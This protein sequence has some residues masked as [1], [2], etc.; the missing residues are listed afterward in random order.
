MGDTFEKV[1]E[2]V[3]DYTPV[4]TAGVKSL[5]FFSL[6]TLGF[7]DTPE[8]GQQVAWLERNASYRS[9]DA[10]AELP[11]LSSSSK[12]QYVGVSRPETPS[13]KLPLFSS[14]S[15]IQYVRVRTCDAVS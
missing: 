7:I 9:Q 5:H 1:I 8:L 10:S 3:S 15:K 13:P 4:G 11:L 12:I 2:D 6:T 14:L